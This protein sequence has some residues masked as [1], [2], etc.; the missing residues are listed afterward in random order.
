MNGK[1]KLRIKQQV[2]SGNSEKTKDEI[3][4]R[5]NRFFRKHHKQCTDDRKR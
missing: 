5:M 4:N 2:V 1:Q 3:Q